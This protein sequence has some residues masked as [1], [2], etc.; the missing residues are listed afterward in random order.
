MRSPDVLAHTVRL[1]ERRL[2]RLRALV[3]PRDQTL[4]PGVNG[5]VD[6][7]PQLFRDRPAGAGVG[8]GLRRT[9]KERPDERPL[10]ER[11]RDD[12]PIG[13]ERV[14]EPRCAALRLFE[15]GRAQHESV[16]DLGD[17]RSDPSTVAESTCEFQCLGDTLEHGGHV[18]FRPCDECKGEEPI[19]EEPLSVLFSIHAEDSLA[20]RSIFL[21]APAG[22]I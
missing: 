18:A 6:V 12:R 9:T 10:C 1:R 8:T 15:H 14:Q 22:W 21:Q 13:H 16:H 2:G 20:D 7:K 19:W 17:A 5:I 11:H 3:V 4:E